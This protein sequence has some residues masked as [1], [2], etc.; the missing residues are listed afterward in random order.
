VAPADH[1]V[2]AL[3]PEAAGQVA[4]LMRAG[5]TAVAY[6]GDPARTLAWFSGFARTG[7]A[8]YAAVVVLED[9]DTSAAARIGQA[10]LQNLP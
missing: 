3:S 10:L 5:H 2:A 8:T 6:S 4:G 7:T 9:G 1:P